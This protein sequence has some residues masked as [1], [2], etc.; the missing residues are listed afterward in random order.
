MKEWWV[1]RRRSS[2]YTFKINFGEGKIVAFYVRLHSRHFR[3]YSSL[4]VSE[5]T[6]VIDAPAETDY[7]R[8]HNQS[9][10]LQGLILKLT[11]EDSTYFELSCFTLL[12]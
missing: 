10:L 11:Q 8:S 5:S 7:L 6:F 3:L 12:N 9:W 4:E 1:L 2:T